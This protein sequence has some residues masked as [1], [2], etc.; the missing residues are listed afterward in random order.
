MTN[1]SFLVS[2]DKSP[3]L[4]SVVIV[5]LKSV[6]GGPSGTKAGGGGGVAGVVVFLGGV[7]GGGGGEGG[8][9]GAGVVLSSTIVPVLLSTR[10]SLVS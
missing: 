4:I 1:E 7:G 2:T 10:L 3:Y 5:Q 9:G 8:F 6:F